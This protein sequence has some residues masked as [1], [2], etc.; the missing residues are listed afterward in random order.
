MKRAFCKV[1]LAGL[2]SLSL[3]SGPSWGRGF[4]GGGF[5]GGGGGFRGGGGGFGGGGFGG[6]G[7][8]FHGGGGFSGGGGFGGGGFSGGG[9]NFGG[10]GFHGGGMPSGGFGGGG[11]SG[12]GGMSGGGFRP[13]PST[14]RPNFGGGGGGG[15]GEGGLGGRGFEG[16]GGGINPGAFHTP[17]SG[18]GLQIGG[19]PELGEGGGRFGAG[20]AGERNPNLGGGGAGGL[21]RP[22]NASLPGLGPSRPGQGG[23]GERLP[24]LSGGGTRPGQGGAGERL[25]GLSG[26]GTRPGQG[27][28]GERLP[29]LSGGGT[30]PGQGGSGERFTPGN[31][32]SIPDRHQDLSN[33]FNDLQNH[34]GDSGWHHENW[35]GP[36]GGDINH[37]GF[38]GPNGYWG[39]TGAWGPNGGHWGHST[40]IGPNGAYS[41]TTGIGPN[42]AVWGHGGAIGPNGAFAYGHYNGPAGHWSRNWGGW[43]N[44][45][46]PCWGTGR[47]N[48]LWNQYPVAMAFG[49]TMWGLNSVAWAFGVGDYYNPYCDGPVYYDNQPIVTYTQPIV[50]DPAYEQTA[51]ADD[52]SA[53][54]SAQTAPTTDPLTEKFDLARLAFYNGNYDDAMKW[55]TE[56]LA[57][58]PRDAAINEFRAL[59]L[60]ATG[61]YRESAATIHSVLAAGPGWNWTTMISLYQQQDTY[62]TQLRA[63][64]DAAKANPDQA[65]LRFLLAYH[66]ITCDHQDAAVVMLK[67]VVR[68]QPKDELAAELLKM[69]TP[70]PDGPDAAKSPA[71]DLEKPAY[72]MEKLRGDWTAKDDSGTF[73]L[74]LGEKDDFQWSFARDGQPQSVSGA[75][76]VRGNNLVMQPDSGGTMLSTITLEA[77]G[78]LKFTP[79]GN[80]HALTFTK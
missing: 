30:R 80:A 62:T 1:G 78:A 63:L 9:G 28:A 50:G 64:E 69:Y 13:S 2:L 4:G 40:G 66:Y 11:F 72:P 14:E 60:F 79:I 38:W 23:A 71:P 46:G 56:A 17:G 20:G 41:R 57:K 76:I 35:N 43:Y 19:R 22:G 77:N 31:P 68:L 54:A 37:V 12:G 32:N 33:R 45:Y 73:K 18:S 48:Y 8:G 5:G 49:A 7:G 59:V 6:G 44:G 75:Y 24:G 21:N 34:W 42:G 47:W 67:D 53:D 70:A 58:A 15:F 65:D 27:G 3:V 55:T 36:N 16:G 61:K 29:G 39:H 51:Q 26:G 52:G 74:H 25:P 10:G